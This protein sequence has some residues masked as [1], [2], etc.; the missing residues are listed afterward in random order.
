L[1]TG[2]K[3]A[4]VAVG[5]TLGVVGML[6]DFKDKTGRLTDGG[7]SISWDWLL[8]SLVGW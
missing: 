3:L 4:A 2:L 8:A 5:G 1:A 7:S 6:N